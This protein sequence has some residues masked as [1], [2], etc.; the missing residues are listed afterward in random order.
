M[1]ELC[2][3]WGGKL[4][5]WFQGHFRGRVESFISAALFVGWL[6]EVNIFNMHLS[7]AEELLL[8]HLL[9]GSAVCPNVCLIP[10]NSRI[11]EIDGNGW[12]RKNSFL[13]FDRKVS[14]VLFK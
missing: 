4:Q 5:T 6:I 10:A 12:R 7:V 9:P 13:I 11:Q 2:V 3:H 14:E 1:L 8:F